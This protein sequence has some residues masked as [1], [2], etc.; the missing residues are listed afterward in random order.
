MCSSDLEQAIAKLR[1]WVQQV[2]RPELGWLSAS[3]DDCWEQHP[4]C[5]YALDWLSELWSVL[6]LQHRRT[7]ATLAG[8]AEW[9]T[10]LLPAVAEQLTRETS[11]C[12]HASGRNGYRT[13][14]RR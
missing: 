1:A 2:Y 7:T 8:Q 6:Y 13:G 4:L 5:L 9:Q 3:L 14:A 11:R 10:R 12:E